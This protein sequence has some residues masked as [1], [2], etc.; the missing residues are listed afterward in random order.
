MQSLLGPQSSEDAR[1]VV[2]SWM[3]CKI[4]LDDRFL[5]AIDRTNFEDFTVRYET[6]MLIAPAQDDTDD[7][8]AGASSVNNENLTKLRFKALLGLSDDHR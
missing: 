4:V 5:V 1:Q 2:K 7:N 6:Y 3:D 8:A